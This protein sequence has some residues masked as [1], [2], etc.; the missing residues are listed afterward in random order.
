MIPK[1]PSA[2]QIPQNPFD[3][4][5]TALRL[6]GYGVRSLDEWRALG[7]KRLALFGVT[8]RMVAELDA[9]E[10]EAWREHH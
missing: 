8:S 6:A 2:P 1:A 5:T 3:N 7:R 4:P 9:L 10:R